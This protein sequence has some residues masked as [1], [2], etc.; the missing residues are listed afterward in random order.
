MADPRF[1]LL[2]FTGSDEVGLALREKARGPKRVALELGGNAAVIVEP[3]AGDLPAVAR[4]IATAAYA[5][6]G[7]SCISVQRVLVHREVAP[8]L[9]DLLV[10]AADAFPTGDPSDERTLCGPMIDAA[11]ARPDRGVDRVGDGRGGTLL[12]GRDAR[13]RPS[14]RPSSRGCPDARTWWRARSS[15]RCRPPGLRGP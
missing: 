5:Y 6:A 1:A 11:N 2:T 9:R 7:Q 15:D 4:R 12:S 8:R 3:D 14:S 10:A 13:V